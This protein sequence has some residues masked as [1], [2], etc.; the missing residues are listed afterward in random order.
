MYTSFSKKPCSKRWYLTW[1]CYYW[2]SISWYFYLTIATGTIF[3]NSTRIRHWCIVPIIVY[4][5]TINLESIISIIH[6]QKGR[7]HILFYWCQKG[8]KICWGYC[9][10]LHKLH[11]SKER[12][13]DLFVLNDELQHAYFMLSILFEIYYLYLKGSMF[14]YCDL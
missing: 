6:I 7:K 9:I 3:Q 4:I 5:K 13:E 14:I 12:L 2:N 10:Y 8:E 1:I 11:I